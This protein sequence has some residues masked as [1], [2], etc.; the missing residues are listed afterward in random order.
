MRVTR[1]S[2]AD[3]AGLQPGD[4]ILRIDGAE[5]GALETLYKTLWRDG[6]ER[7]VTLTSAAAA[8]RRR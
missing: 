6:A 2:P 5:V 8:S 4:R 1:D 3:A 7:E